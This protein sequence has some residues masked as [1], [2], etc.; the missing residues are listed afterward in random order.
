MRC[1]SR[2][3][4]N[5]VFRLSVFVGV[6]W[7]CDLVDNECVTDRSNCFVVARNL[8]CEC[9]GEVEDTA[10]RAGSFRLALGE[11][12]WFLIKIDVTACLRR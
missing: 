12:Q 1:S 4:I 3:S 9:I 5:F 8:C 6:P 11:L 2:K 7:Q 10:L